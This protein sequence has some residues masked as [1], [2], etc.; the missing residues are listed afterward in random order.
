MQTLTVVVGGLVPAPY[1]FSFSTH[2]GV[3]L[4][5]ACPVAARSR[6]VVE[7]SRGPSAPEGGANK[8]AAKREVAATAAAETGAGSAGY[9]PA[10]VERVVGR[11]TVRL[12]VFDI[13]AVFA[14][15]GEKGAKLFDPVVQVSHRSGQLGYRQTSSLYCTTP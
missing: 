5:Q 2:L 8:G 10:L 4:T 7:L 11:E 13:A 12:A 3:A 15:K 6:V 9:T 14:Q 1:P